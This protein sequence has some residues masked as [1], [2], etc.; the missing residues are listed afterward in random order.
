M[1]DPAA[2]FKCKVVSCTNITPRAANDACEHHMWWMH[3]VCMW[4][5]GYK[6]AFSRLRA[7]L[8]HALC[9]WCREQSM[10]QSPPLL[11]NDTFVGF[12][13]TASH[14]R[15][16]LP[17]VLSAPS[18]LIG[19]PKNDAHWHALP[20]HWRGVAVSLTRHWRAASNSSTNGPCSLNWTCLMFACPNTSFWPQKL[21]TNFWSIKTK[22]WLSPHI[23]GEYLEILPVVDSW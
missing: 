14:M 7:A 9:V 15:C 22:S 8:S 5:K 3:V 21:R 17:L 16:L 11:A 10:W 12:V 20:W 6:A 4:K 23:S 2:Y 13:P 18:W 1:W 19:K